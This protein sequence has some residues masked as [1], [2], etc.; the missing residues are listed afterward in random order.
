M[1]NGGLRNMTYKLKTSHEINDVS[2]RISY[3]MIRL[4]RMGY[5]FDIAEEKHRIYYEFHR[6][7]VDMFVYGIDSL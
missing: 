1:T 3:D 7:Y 6:A 4:Y 5:K 2:N